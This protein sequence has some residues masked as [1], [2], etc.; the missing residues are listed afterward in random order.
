MST[1]DDIVRAARVYVDH[2]R[3]W[4]QY[5]NAPGGEHAKEAKRRALFALEM[6]IDECEEEE[7][8]AKRK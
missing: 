4:R 6:A 7:D 1:K 3:L 2:V 5:Q 8:S